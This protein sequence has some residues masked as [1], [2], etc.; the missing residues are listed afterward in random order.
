MVHSLLGKYD[1]KV[2]TNIVDIRNVSKLARADKT[3]DADAESVNRSLINLFEKP[4][5]S[6]K[7]AYDTSAAMSYMRRSLIKKIT[8]LSKDLQD[9]NNL[10]DQSVF[11]ALDGLVE[12]I[13][14]Y[15][16]RA[17]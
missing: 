9:K 11:T 16:G 4:E 13:Q 5:V 12:A 1:N 15:K 2:I 10:E 7:E 17:G 3:S 6:I 14:E 8:D